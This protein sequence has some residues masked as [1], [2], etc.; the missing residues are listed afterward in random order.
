MKLQPCPD[1]FLDTARFR[2]ENEAILAGSP[3]KVF[4][5]VASIEHEANWFPDFK[6]ARWREPGVP[7]AGAIRDYRLTYLTLVEH[8]TVWEPGERLTF[9]VSDCSLPLLRR[10]LENYEF[11]AVADGTTRLRWTV[12]YDPLGFV[13]PLHPLLRPHFSRD[14]RRATAN[15]VAYCR[16][17]HGAEPA[18]G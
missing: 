7:G 6:D 10:F 11:S 14:F 15:L 5:V 4:D 18:A 16:R 9:W 3:E 17:L 8:F 1:D 2:F 13:R 12:A